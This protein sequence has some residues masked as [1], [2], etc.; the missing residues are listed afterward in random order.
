MAKGMIELDDYQ[1]AARDTVTALIEGDTAKA[2]AISTRERE[3]SAEM[4]QRYAR[5]VTRIDTPDE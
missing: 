5:S 4:A 2:H 3:R 1:K